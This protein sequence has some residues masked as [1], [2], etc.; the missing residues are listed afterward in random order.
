MT[1][2]VIALS[3]ASRAL[4]GSVCAEGR[5]GTGIYVNPDGYLIT[6]RHVVEGVHHAPFYMRT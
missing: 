3:S 1:R 6:N 5:R 2:L 4:S